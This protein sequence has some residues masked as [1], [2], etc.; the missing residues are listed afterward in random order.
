[1]HWVRKNI[2]VIRRGAHFTFPPF[3]DVVFASLGGAPSVN[4]HDLTPW[5]SWF[6][7]EIYT[8]GDVQRLIDSGPVDV[9]LAHDVCNDSTSAVE[10]MLATNPYG[11]PQ[12]ALLYAAQGRALLD[13]VRDALKPK[14]WLHGHYHVSQISQS[15]DTVF[16]AL[17]H[18]HGPVEQNYALVDVINFSVEHAGVSFLLN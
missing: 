18:D 12:D 2:A 16:A 3:D 13:E 14:L 8:I 10:R 17:A 5:V 15:E 6:P 4:L 1:M 9:L 11:W 7:T